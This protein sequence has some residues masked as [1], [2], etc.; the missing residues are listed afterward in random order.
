MLDLDRTVEL[1]TDIHGHSR[2]Y[3]VFM[4]GCAFSEYTLDSRNNSAI[5]VFPSLLHERLDAFNIKDCRFALEK[6]KEATARIVLFKELS[7]INCFT[8]ES[9]FYGTEPE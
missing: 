6:E 4:Y 1:Y 2:K 9:S 5:K 7:I 8:M 3:N